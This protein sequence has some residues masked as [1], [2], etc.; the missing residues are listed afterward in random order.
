[1]ITKWHGSIDGI[2]CKH[3]QDKETKTGI[4][5]LGALHSIAV[6]PVLVVSFTPINDKHRSSF[7]AYDFWKLLQR[8]ISY[9]IFAITDQHWFKWWSV[10]IPLYRRQLVHLQSQRCLNG[11]VYVH[12]A[13]VIGIYI[14]H[15]TNPYTQNWYL[16]RHFMLI[17][18]RP[19]VQHDLYSV[20]SVHYRHHVYWSMPATMFL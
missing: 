13:N 18:A 12:V 6:V 20:E 4:Y 9:R 7:E 3:G 15:A 16:R 2:A 17:I 8:L 19:T 10:F 1:M 5:L 14:L 11:L